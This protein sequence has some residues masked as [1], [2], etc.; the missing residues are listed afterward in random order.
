MRRIE[1]DR[2]GLRRIKKE[3]G[4]RKKQERESAQIQRRKHQHT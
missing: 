1:K 3:E 2:E 4:R